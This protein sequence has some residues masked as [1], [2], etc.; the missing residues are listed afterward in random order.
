M[1]HDPRSLVG[2]F[3][4]EVGVRQAWP[5]ITFTINSGTMTPAELRLYIDTT[6]EVIPPPPLVFDPAAQAPAS[7]LPALLE[8][9]NL[10]VTAVT[11]ADN[12]NLVLGFEGGV[13]LQVPGTPSAWTTHDV[14]W[15]GDPRA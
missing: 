8:V 10:T 6:C 12:G 2:F 15:L 4:T 3:V 5:F 1:H 13:T 9:L 7:A 11:V 14:W